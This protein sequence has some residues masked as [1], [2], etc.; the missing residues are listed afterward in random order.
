[1]LSL[2]VLELQKSLF[3]GGHGPWDDI[4]GVFHGLAFDVEHPLEEVLVLLGDFSGDV[5]MIGELHLEYLLF[6]LDRENVG[7]QGVSIL[8]PG[9]IFLRLFMC[10][11]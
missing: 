1:M 9:L 3:V 6:L 2:S 4:D 8:V 5:L 7:F 11:W 10:F